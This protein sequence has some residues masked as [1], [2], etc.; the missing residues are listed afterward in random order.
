MRELGYVDEKN[1]LFEDRYAEGGKL[2]RLPDLAADWF[3]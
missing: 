3:V 1:V 2:D